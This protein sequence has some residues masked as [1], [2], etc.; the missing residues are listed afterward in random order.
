MP[1]GTAMPRLMAALDEL[2]RNV[3]ADLKGKPAITAQDRR[4]MR[5]DIEKCMQQLDELR[6]M[7]AG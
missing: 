3:R 1:F 7:L 2:D 5:S 6:T 4:T